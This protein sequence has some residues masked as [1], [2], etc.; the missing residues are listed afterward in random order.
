[1]P[2]PW[3]APVV[4]SRDVDATGGGGG[5]HVT[6]MSVCMPTRTDESKFQAL[7]GQ[8]IQ[9]ELSLGNWPI[10]AHKHVGLATS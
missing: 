2:R 6:A 7:I 1:M 5:R 3:L 10:L 4:D 9:Q 8:Q